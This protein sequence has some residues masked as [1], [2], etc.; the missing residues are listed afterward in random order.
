ML[1]NLY[2][3]NQ[4]LNNYKIDEYILKNLIQKYVSIVIQPK[5]KTYHLLLQI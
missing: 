5:N 2:Y 3:K 1:I 4:F